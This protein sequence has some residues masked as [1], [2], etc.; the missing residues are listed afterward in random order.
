MGSTDRL[1][2]KQVALELG[3]PFTTVTRLVRRGELKAERSGPPGT[4]RILRSD[5]DSYVL[6]RRREIAELDERR[7]QKAQRARAAR[8]DALRKV[9]C[10]HMPGAVFCGECEGHW[11]VQASGIT[12]VFD[13]DA[14]A[15]KVMPG[16]VDDDDRAPL[17]PLL[18]IIADGFGAVSMDA[19][20]EVP[21]QDLGGATG[22]I[23][24]Y[25]SYIA[26]M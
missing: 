1:R 9:A 14:G 13:L 10:A 4:W 12:Y 15:I 16:D 25:V 22:L 6:D 5:L 7:A 18:L 2:V 26:R 23:T 20:M 24:G 3:L 19:P 11:V 21:V 8:L 17:Y